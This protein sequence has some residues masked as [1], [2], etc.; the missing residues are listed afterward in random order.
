MLAVHIR[1]SFICVWTLAIV[2]EVPLLL[3]YA[4]SSSFS[5]LEEPAASIEEAAREYQQLMF[6]HHSNV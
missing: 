5:L 4:S 2:T 6:T 3:E 1:S